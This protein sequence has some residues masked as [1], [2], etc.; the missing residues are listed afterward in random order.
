MCTCG[1]TYWCLKWCTCG[2]RAHGMART[3]DVLGS[4]F[5]IPVNGI[6]SHSTK[7]DYMST[8]KYVNW[9]FGVVKSLVTKSHVRRLPFKL[10]PKSH[11][12]LQYVLSIPSPNETVFVLIGLWEEMDAFMSPIKTG[13][14]DYLMQVLIIRLI[15]CIFCRKIEHYGFQKLEPVRLLWWYF[16]ATLSILWI[17]L[18][19]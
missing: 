6:Y 2:L 5:K 15:C 14:K 11:L 4:W 10:F 12:I 16:T 3:A 13:A 7:L 9:L 8:Q 17:S 18:V 1:S 19:L